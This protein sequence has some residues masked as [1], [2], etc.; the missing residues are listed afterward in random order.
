MYVDAK[1]HTFG[2]HL[3]DA[4]VDVTLLHL[5]I[6][7]PVAQQAADAVA[8]FKKDDIVPGSRELLRARHACGC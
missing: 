4:T 8:L 7:D 6:G 2:A 3:L 5:E 1:I